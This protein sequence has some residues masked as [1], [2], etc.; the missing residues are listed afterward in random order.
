MGE[1]GGRAKPLAIHADDDIAGCQAA[2]RSRAAWVRA[3]DYYVSN[4][5]IG[6]SDANT[7]VAAAGD[8]KWP[9]IHNVGVVLAVGGACFRADAQAAR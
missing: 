9:D 4:R 2:H 7:N 1:L 8:C 5:A 3:N 6:R